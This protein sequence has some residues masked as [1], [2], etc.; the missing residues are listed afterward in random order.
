VVISRNWAR[1][2][3]HGPVFVRT[4]LAFTADA[5]KRIRPKMQRWPLAAEQDFVICSS[6][7][8]GTAFDSSPQFSRKNREHTVYASEFGPTLVPR[9]CLFCG[10]F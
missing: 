1:A 7:G 3:R 4:D 10:H 2:E 5:A 8:G 9:T 6:C